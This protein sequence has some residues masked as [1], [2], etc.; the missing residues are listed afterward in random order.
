VLGRHSY[1]AALSFGAGGAARSWRGH[2]GYAYAR[3]V[4]W[5]LDASYSRDLAVVDTVPG[6]GAAT[7]CNV[8]EDAAMG[9]SWVHARWRWQVRARAGAEYER[10]GGIRRA[11]GVLSAA[12]WH[13]T[14]PEYA[15]S[16]QTGW[17]AAALVRERWRTDTALA[18]QEA[19]AAGAAY[20]ALPLGGFARPVLAVTATAGRLGGS[21]RVVYGVGGLTQRGV[22]VL[23]GLDLGG[24]GPT[25]PVRG[26]PSNA[27]LG[28]AAAS[29]SAELRLPLALVERGL[30]L[31]PLFLDRMSVTV[32]TDVGATWTPRG[33][34]SSLP[35]SSVIGSGGAELVVDLG[36]AYSV[37]LRLRA[38]AAWPFSQGRSVTGY[39]AVGPSF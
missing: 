35:A 36:V 17:R 2:V 24:S 12:A 25:F 3:L 29:G 27:I 9:A 5:V 38:G 28:R 6:G 15:I 16:L 23:P 7:C 33:F 34:T 13:L 11:G 8:D 22:S 31:V 20:Q 21:D 1:D 30:G 26:Y 10:N 39:V 4:P 18:Y 14:Q 19:L 37:P 32:F